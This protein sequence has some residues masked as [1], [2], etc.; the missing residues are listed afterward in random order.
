MS[1]ISGSGAYYDTDPIAQGHSGW[2]TK[3][4][5]M[6]QAPRLCCLSCGTEC[7][8]DSKSMHLCISPYHYVW[9]HFT[10]FREVKTVM[11]E[12]DVALCFGVSPGAVALHRGLQPEIPDREFAPTWSYCSCQG[13]RSVYPC[14]LAYSYVR[15]RFSESYQ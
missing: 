2:F 10:E 9:S 15:S 12:S 1:Q 3:L 8:T 7:G 4:R 6:C 14:V 13:D 11:Q 5:E